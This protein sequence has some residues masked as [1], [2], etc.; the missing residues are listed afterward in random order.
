MKKTAILKVIKEQFNLDDKTAN[1][2]ILS[3]KVFVNEIKICKVGTPVKENDVIRIKDIKKYV[4]RGAY[5]LLAAFNKFK[6]DV[7]NKVCLDIGSSTGGFTQVL[8]EKNAKKVYSVDCGINQLDYNLRINP[9]VIALENKRIQDLKKEDCQD[10]IDIAVMDV[11]FTSAIPI[12]HYLAAE[13]NLKNLV[14]LIK[15]QFEYERLRKQLNLPEQF[16]GVISNND[17]LIKI[18]TAI[19][20]EILEIGF[21]IKDFVESPIKGAKGNVEYLFELGKN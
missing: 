16:N 18:L 15:P 5:K 17:I 20:E 13:F 6:L 9:R 2:L 19:Q 3:G 21:N 10:I 12:I 4:S 14:I 8:L 1:G 7:N 11:S